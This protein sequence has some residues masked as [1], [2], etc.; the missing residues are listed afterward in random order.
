MSNYTL[1]SSHQEFIVM[2]SWSHA[3]TKVNSKFTYNNYVYIK[4]LEYKLTAVVDNITH[5]TNASTESKCSIVNA[6]YGSLRIF[7]TCQ[8]VKDQD[9]DPPEVWCKHIA[10]HI[11]TSRR[12]HIQDQKVSNKACVIQTQNQLT[13]SVLGCSCSLSINVSQSQ[14]RLAVKLIVKKWN[15]LY[16]Y[17]DAP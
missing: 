3:Q 15:Y 12:I 9:E 5:I 10:H 13:I 14:N 1:P 11:K 6:Y 17:F 8:Q 16:V 4:S 7:L 2:N